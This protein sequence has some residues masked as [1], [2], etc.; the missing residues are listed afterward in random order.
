MDGENKLLIYLIKK[1]SDTLRDDLHYSGSAEADHRIY[2]RCHLLPIHFYDGPLRDPAT[3]NRINNIL[4]CGPL[5][6]TN[7]HR[8]YFFRPRMAKRETEGED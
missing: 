8:N 4:R 5:H 2:N 3:W 1:K 7:V 6:N